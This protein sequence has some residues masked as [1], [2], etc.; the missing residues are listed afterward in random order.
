VDL[1]SIRPHLTYW[2]LR[3]AWVAAAALWGVALVPWFGNPEPAAL[4]APAAGPARNDSAADT[5]TLALP[6]EEEV[7]ERPEPVFVPQRQRS[8]ESPSAA[9][10][11]RGR[12][13]SAVC[14]LNDATAAG[15]AQRA[16]HVARQASLGMQQAFEDLRSR[17]EPQ[18]QAAALWLRVLVAREG[19]AEAPTPTAPCGAGADCA[20]SAASAASAPAWP[21]VPAA[22]DALAQLALAGSDAWQTQIAARA[23]DGPAPPAVCASLANRRWSTLEPDNAA[24][25]LEQSARDAASVD[26]AL[27]RAARAARFDSH[28]GRLASW[29]L[30]AMPERVPVMQ[31]YAAWQRTDE[32]ERMVDAKVM[33]AAARHCSDTARRD[34][35]RGQVCDALARWLAPERAQANEPPLAAPTRALDCPT[36]ERQWRE[37]R[38]AA[39]RAGRVAAQGSGTQ[40]P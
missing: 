26:E 4:D 17:S 16:A 22:I 33:T 27:F 10:S 38:D 2:A 12:N 5:Q 8:A 7:V 24:A 6:R 36:L 3:G 20:A 29:V 31:R 34:A 32:L 19:A 1:A 14:G 25:W 35:N 28:R 40:R 18:A 21:A 13:D 37:A 11:E 23:C 15:E 30:Q 39:P 9:P